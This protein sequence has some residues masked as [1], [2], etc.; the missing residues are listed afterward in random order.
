LADGFGHIRSY[1]Y[2]EGPAAGFMLVSWVD[3]E[4]DALVAVGQI[5]VDMAAA[6]KAEAR[7]RVA[8]G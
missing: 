6:L 7:R 5:G 2:V 1:G 3:L 8:S 4:A